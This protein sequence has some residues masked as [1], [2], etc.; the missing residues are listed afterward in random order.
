VNH[1]LH[2]YYAV[3][4]NIMNEMAAQYKSLLY[5]DKCKCRLKTISTEEKIKTN[6]R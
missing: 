4:K 6:S 5:R 2:K 1:L 3:A